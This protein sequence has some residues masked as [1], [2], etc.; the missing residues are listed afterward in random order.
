M[1]EVK[2]YKISL[3]SANISQIP[4]KRDWMDETFD[5]HAYKCFPVTLTNS[6]GWGLS[7]PEDISFIWDGISDSSANHVKILS[8]EKYCY[9]ERGN[10]TISF[11]TG[12]IL[13]TNQDVTLLQMPVPNMFIDG[14]Q[15][16][17]TLIST[18]FFNSEFPCALRIT[19][20]NSIITIKA[21]QPIISII[22]LSLNFIDNSEIKF[23][24]ISKMPKPKFNNNEYSK[25]VQEITSSGSWTNFYRNATDHKGN[26]IGEHELKSLKFKVTNE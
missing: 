23:E 5:A 4:V 13:K 3:N 12:L 8:G 9:A 7:F 15:S 10:S 6:L 18:S 21:N 20:P 26:K 1:Y 11:R 16:F 19:K 22:P 24:S 25:A 17:T 2:A 14:V